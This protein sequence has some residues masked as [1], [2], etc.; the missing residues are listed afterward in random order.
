MRLHVYIYTQ[1]DFI[2]DIHEELREG[3]LNICA[4]S[5]NV[6]LSSEIVALCVLNMFKTSDK[7][8]EETVSYFESLISDEDTDTLS[9]ILGSIIFESCLKSKRKKSFTR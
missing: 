9:V 4:N 3:H 1:E 2:S 6:A 8:L 7:S 5:I